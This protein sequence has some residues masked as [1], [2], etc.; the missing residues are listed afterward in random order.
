M[1]PDPLL[2]T[3]GGPTSKMSS[4][5]PKMQDPTSFLL[6]KLRM[7]WNANHLSFKY[8]DVAIYQVADDAALRQV[9]HDI[10]FK[11]NGIPW[12]K[13]KYKT[14]KERS[15]LSVELKDAAYVGFL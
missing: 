11:P 6:W 2:I 1:I 8:S 15:T 13:I 10:V 7:D 9:L 4:K 14:P 12:K 3:W 5:P